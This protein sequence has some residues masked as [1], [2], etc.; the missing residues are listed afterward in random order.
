MKDKENQTGKE[1]NLLTKILKERCPNCGK[2]EVFKKK[3]SIF[4][5]PVMNDKCE[6]CQYYFDREPGYFIGAMYIS[7]GLAVLQGI[8]TFLIINTFFSEVS[9]IYL[10]LIIVAVI[11][12]FSLKNYKLSR[13][14]YMHIFPD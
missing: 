3:N 8:L 5:L 10:V 14:I 13:I 2:G 11:A 1:E 6:K 9:T 4:E 7:Y 12:A